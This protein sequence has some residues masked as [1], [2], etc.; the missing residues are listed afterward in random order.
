VDAA[1]KHWAIPDILWASRLVSI[2][3][4]M[5]LSLVAWVKASGPVEPFS[6]QIPL[7]IPSEQRANLPLSWFSLK[8]RSD[9]LR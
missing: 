8:W 5:P 6:K 9:V 2:L 1:G 4:M 3:L 7:G